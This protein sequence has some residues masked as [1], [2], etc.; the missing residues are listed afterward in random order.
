MPPWKAAHH[1]SQ[2]IPAGHLLLHGQVADLG[3][4]RVIPSECQQAI[5]T[6]TYGTVT[7]QP[8]ELLSHG[9]VSPAC[10]V[11]AFGFLMWEV[12]TG[13]EVFKDLSDVAVVLAVVNQQARPWWPDDCPPR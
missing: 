4:S 12:F 6:R 11:Y 13:E 7:H 3:L 9:E 10:D 5:K 8:P 1:Q 2:A